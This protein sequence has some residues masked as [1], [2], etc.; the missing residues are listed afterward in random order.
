MS[1]RS[2]TME[3]NLDA[4]ARLSWRKRQ[5]SD[6]SKLDAFADRGFALMLAK[7]MQWVSFFAG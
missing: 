5:A 3:R 2:V 1:S 4:T 6:S 7:E